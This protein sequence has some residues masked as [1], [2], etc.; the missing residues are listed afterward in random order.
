MKNITA[1]QRAVNRMMFQLKQLQ[2]KYADAANN[3]EAFGIKK[4]LTNQMRAIE[5]EL[6][7]AEISIQAGMVFNIFS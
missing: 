6:K 7:S 5:Q 4:E 1:G 3:G 2:N